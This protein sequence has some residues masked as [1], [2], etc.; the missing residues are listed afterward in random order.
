MLT[1]AIQRYIAA[2][3]LDTELREATRAFAVALRSSHNRESSRMGTTLEQICGR[4]GLATE[5]VEPP[6]T[7]AP[8][9]EPAPV[10]TPL[11]LNNLKLALGITNTVPEHTGVQI[12]PDRFPLP[13]DPR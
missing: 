7:A 11:V 2:H 5:E 10:G 4:A 3:E 9:P 8:P 13:P 1:Q 6:R 12:E